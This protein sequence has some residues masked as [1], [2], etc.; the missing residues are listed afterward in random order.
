MYPDSGYKRAHAQS[1]CTGSFSRVGRGL[2]TRL[3]GGGIYNLWSV[4]VIIIK[5]VCRHRFLL[6]AN[7]IEQSSLFLSP[8][9]RATIYG[10]ALRSKV[11]CT[12]V[13][14]ITT[15]IRL[16]HSIPFQSSPFHH[17]IPP[18]QSTES[19]HPPTSK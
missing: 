5:C 6:L 13:A 8:F 14:T 17:S 7:K 19:I 15:F 10:Q 12:H 1:V 16:F 2:G 4:S 18:F 11:E 9:Q 3:V